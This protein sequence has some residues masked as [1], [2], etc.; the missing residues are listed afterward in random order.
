[1]IQFNPEIKSVLDEMLLGNPLV[2][3]GKMFG[4][5]A[6]FVGKKLCLC[7]YEDGVGLKLPEQRA[8]Q[9]LADDA[10][11]IPFQPL[12]R[13][14]MRQWVQINLERPEDYRSYAAVFDE[15]IQYILSLA[16][17]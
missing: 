7:V 15:A 5:P 3:A 1:M 10:H 4:L 17:A 8:R 9:L 14:K 11:V 6:Y 2:S 16:Y 13:R 12:G